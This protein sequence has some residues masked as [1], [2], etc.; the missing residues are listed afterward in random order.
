MDWV[1][2]VSNIF[3]SWVLVNTVGLMTLG[4]TKGTEF[5]DQLSDYQLLEKGSTSEISSA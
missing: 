2:L 5:T 4:T 3:Q 1:Q